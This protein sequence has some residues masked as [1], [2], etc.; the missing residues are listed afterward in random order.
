MSIVKVKKIKNAL[1]DLESI[2]SELEDVINKLEWSQTEY[3]VVP[4]DTD[5]PV[6][7]MKWDLIIQHFKDLSYLQTHDLLKTL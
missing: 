3:D 1:V 5:D 2:K 7:V 4:V 6:D